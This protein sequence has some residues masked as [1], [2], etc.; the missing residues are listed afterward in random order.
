MKFTLRATKARERI[1]V[2]ERILRLE[3][4][5]AASIIT[6]HARPAITSVHS[7][8]VVVAEKIIGIGVLLVH[9]VGVI[10][11]AKHTIGVGRTDHHAAAAGHIAT[12]TFGHLHILL[13]SLFNII[14]DLSSFNYSVIFGSQFF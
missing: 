4:V 10:L 6:V 8:G 3:R 14:W 9:H 2:A 11:V 13:N 12:K 1:I 5:H 7:I